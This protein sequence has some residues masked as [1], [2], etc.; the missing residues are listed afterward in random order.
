MI[1]SLKSEGYS[2]LQ[3]TSKVK[4]VMNCGL[5]EAVQIVLDSPSWVDHKGSFLKQQNQLWSDLD[6]EADETETDS[7]GKVIY[8]FHVKSDKDGDESDIK[9]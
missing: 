5:G 8:T 9:G 4:Q 6:K 1:A 2:L 3:T 7:D